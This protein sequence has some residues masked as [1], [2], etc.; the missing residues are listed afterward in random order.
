MLIYY[1][2]R[3][4]TTQPDDASHTNSSKI[5]HSTLCDCFVYII[6]EKKN[7]ENTLYIMKEDC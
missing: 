4:K 3:D 2:Q 1:L 6:K 5:E 7:T